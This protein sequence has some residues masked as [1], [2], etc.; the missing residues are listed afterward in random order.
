MP[1]LQPAQWWQAES[2]RPTLRGRWGWEP[3]WI[4]VKSR[5]DT[6]SEVTWFPPSPLPRQV[7]RWLAYSAEAMRGEGI[8]QLKVRCLNY[9]GMLF[10]HTCE[11]QSFYLFILFL[12]VS[13]DLFQLLLPFIRTHPQSLPQH[14]HTKYGK[15]RCRNVVSV[16]P[17]NNGGGITKQD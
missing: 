8:N 11:L 1:L 5:C 16:D 7:L 14:P 12:Y 10:S 6:F 3:E 13:L 4:S 15:Q 17:W 9:A 2:G